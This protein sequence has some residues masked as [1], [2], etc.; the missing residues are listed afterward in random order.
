MFQ[1]NVRTDRNPKLCIYLRASNQP[2]SNCLKKKLTNKEEL[3]GASL[4]VRPVTVT[5]GEDGEI[6]R[7]EGDVLESWISH[8]YASQD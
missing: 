2:T 4:E 3:P 5:I 1:F 7:T 8:G 6:A